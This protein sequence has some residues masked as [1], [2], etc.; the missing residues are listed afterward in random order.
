[1]YR[2]GRVDG[3]RQKG[4]IGVGA[5]LVRC[6]GPLALSVAWKSTSTSRR[7]VLR[8]RQISTRVGLTETTAMGRTRSVAIAEAVSKTL[9]GRFTVETR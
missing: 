9:G 5:P 7:P 8:A 2:N 3:S 6:W 1:M 4:G